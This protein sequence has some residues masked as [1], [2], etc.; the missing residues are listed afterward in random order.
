MADRAFKRNAGHLVGELITLYAEATIGASGAPTLVAANSPGVASIA[1]NGTGDYTLTL[2]DR[3]GHL[4]G[5]NVSFRDSVAQ[6]ISEVIEDEAGTDVSSKTVQLN[7][8]N[9][10]G[11]A[12]DPQNGSTMRILL[13]LNNTSDLLR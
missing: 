5:H 4:L 2:S 7:C 10:G 8:F 3:Y 6:D 9:E 13:F 12:T 11:T 1:Q